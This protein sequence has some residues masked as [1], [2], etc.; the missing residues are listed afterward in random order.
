MWSQKAV[1]LVSLADSGLLSF[2]DISC[3]VGE[4]HRAGNCGKPVAKNL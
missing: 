4:A 2:N 3:L 1:A